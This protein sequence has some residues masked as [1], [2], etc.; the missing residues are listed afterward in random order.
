MNRSLTGHW[1]QWFAGKY[2]H[3]QLQ[4][5][6]TSNDLAW[7]GFSSLCIAGQLLSIPSEPTGVSGDIHCLSLS[8]NGDLLTCL[9]LDISGHGPAIAALSERIEIPL[10]KLL[11]DRD[12]RGLLHALNKL[13]VDMDLAGQFATAVARTYDTVDRMWRYAYAGHPNMLL[14]EDGSWSE[15]IAAGN[16]GIPA[17]I[18][19]DAVFYQYECQLKAGDRLLLYTD[20][21]TDIRLSAGNWLGTQGLLE[22]LNDLGN[23]DSRTTM[24]R[25]MDGLVGTNTSD[26]FVDDVTLLMLECV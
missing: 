10:Q 14:F 24:V 5:V 11:D 21:V 9:L 20:G 13:L 12:N 22:M 16:H 4:G 19:A 2:D 7:C 25:L 17:G 6:H 23:E 15:L 1:H 18:V 8:E 26:V 3:F